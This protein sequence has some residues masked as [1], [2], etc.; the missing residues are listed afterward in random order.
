MHHHCPK[1]TMNVVAG[2]A[3]ILVSVLLTGC[4]SVPP[5]VV[6]SAETLKSYA[7]KLGGGQ[8]QVMD[9]Y[10][11]RLSSVNTTLAN[12]ARSYV[13]EYEK[14]VNTLARHL[15]QL[16][17]T[18]D[19]LAAAVAGVLDADGNTTRAS[20]LSAAD[21]DTLRR[22]LQGERDRRIQRNQAKAEI[23]NPGGFNEARQTLQRTQD[24]IQS[25]SSEVHKLL[26]ERLK[27]EYAHLNQ[28]FDD[29]IAYLRSLVKVRDE[30]KRVLAGLEK[31]V[32]SLAEDV[33]QSKTFNQINGILNLFSGGQQP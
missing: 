32:E 19:R 33:G 31:R 18:Y 7:N 28:G 20:L 3:A 6:T 5:Q 1:P 10:Q 23:I 15:D 9:R 14:D 11:Q 30:R 2:M 13:N 8:V 12:S 29:L 4:V 25:Q 16:T 17:E 24:Q 21:G 26:G 27:D 22:L